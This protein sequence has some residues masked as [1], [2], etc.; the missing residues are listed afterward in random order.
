MALTYDTLQNDTTGRVIFRGIWGSHAFG[1]AT[2]EQKAETRASWNKWDVIHSV[3][4][5]S[6]IISFY[7]C[8]W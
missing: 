6:V 8:F 4:I 1:T 7:V 3:I 2:P 5:L